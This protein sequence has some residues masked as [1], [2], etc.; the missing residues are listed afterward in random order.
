MLQRGYIGRTFLHSNVRTSYPWWVNLAKI[1]CLHAFNSF[2]YTSIHF[3]RAAPGGLA[4]IDSSEARTVV[5]VSVA[6]VLRLSEKYCGSLRCENECCQ[7]SMVGFC[8]VSHSPQ[9]VNS[10]A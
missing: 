7:I 4:R 2:N 8:Y 3:D 9:D 1:S 6:P 5:V 10:Y